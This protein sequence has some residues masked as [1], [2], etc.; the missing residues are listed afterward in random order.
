M[1]VSVADRAPTAIALVL[2]GFCGLQPLYFREKPSF[3]APRGSIVRNLVLLGS[4]VCNLCILAK[5]PVSGH[6]AGEFFVS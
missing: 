4:G 2:L 1:I 5:N 6:L 3:S